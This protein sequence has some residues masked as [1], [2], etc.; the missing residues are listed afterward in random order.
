MTPV[1]LPIDRTLHGTLTLLVALA[2]STAAPSHARAADVPAVRTTA[3]EAAPIEV[4]VERVRPAREKLA[5]MRF[6]DA[7]REFFRSRLDRLREV[8][9]KRKGDAEEMDPRF[10]TYGAMLRD[11]M[12]AKDTVGQAEFERQRRQLF[13]SV[14]ELSA[15]EARLDGMDRLLAEQ[16]ERLAV[17]QQDFD[18]RQRTALAVVV[19]GWPQDAGV[20]ALSI[21]F[22]DGDTLTVPVSEAERAS[23]QHGGVLE[24]FHGLVEPRE[25]LFEI[26]LA[27]ERWPAGEQGFLTLDLERDRLTML[28]LDLSPVRAASGA[29]G[30]HATT[31]LHDA[32]LAANAPEPSE[33]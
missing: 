32:G 4:R 20:S 3:S 27:G 23:L 15:L 17:L 14:A 9:L 29:G 24:L 28:R 6:L 26:A 33:P 30:I 31:W 22:E 25:Q 8:S 10:L 2:A 5:T 18:G 11:V 21:R 19:S 1:T 7:N 13:A 16:R 12:A